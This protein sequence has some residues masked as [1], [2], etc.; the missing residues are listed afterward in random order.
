MVRMLIKQAHK[1]LYEKWFPLCKV[2]THDVRGVG[3]SIRFNH[4]RSM[5]GILEAGTWKCDNV[6][7]NHYLKE[8][9]IDY[10]N[11]RR[12]GPFVAGGAIIEF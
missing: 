3:T 7:I 9:A 2:K 12:L 8:V 4:N 10:G 5:A 1:E 11:C 6:F